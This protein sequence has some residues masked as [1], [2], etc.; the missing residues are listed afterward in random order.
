MVNSFG[1]RLPS[2]IGAAAHLA[3]GFRAV[4]L[5]SALFAAVVGT[6]F[7]HAHLEASSPAVDSAVR[8]SPK[9]VTVTLTEKLEAG[10]SRIEVR[11]ASGKQVDRGDTRVSKDDPR[12]ISVSVGDLAPGIYSVKWS[13]T[14]VDTHGTDGSFRFTIKP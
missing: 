9:E 3:A 12:T 10:L 11:D 5:S 8:I 4:A 7:A 14:S 13:V 6:A 1:N 2:R